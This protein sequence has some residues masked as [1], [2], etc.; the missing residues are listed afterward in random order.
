MIPQEGLYYG[1]KRNHTTLYD[2]R[3]IPISLESLY[4]RL[5]HLNVTSFYPLIH[6]HNSTIL[7]SEP[8]Q[9]DVSKLPLIIRERDAEYQFHRVMLFKRLLYVIDIF[10]LYITSYTNVLFVFKHNFL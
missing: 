7:K 2:P 9:Y 10:Y 5:N 8:E 3:V 4:M 1:E 6:T